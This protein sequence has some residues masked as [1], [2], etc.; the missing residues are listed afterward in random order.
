MD[1]KTI[2]E[3]IRNN[4]SKDLIKILYKTALPPIVR[5][6]KQ[7]GGQKSDAEDC[8]QEAVIG[9]VK[10]VNDNTY[11]DQ[12]EVKNFLFILARNS[13]YNKLRRKGTVISVELEDF[14]MEDESLNSEDTMISVERE[15]AINQLMNLAGERCKQLLKLILFENKKMKEVAVLLG[16][17]SEEVVKTNH[18]R[19]KKKLKEALKNDAELLQALK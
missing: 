14:Q 8:F 16:I 3:A 17:S 15:S 11:D 6:I 7:K 1:N 2:I 4:N 5:H 10:K 13:W 19:C 12:Y 9:L 18:Y